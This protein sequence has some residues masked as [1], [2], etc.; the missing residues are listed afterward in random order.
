MP[1]NPNH[2]SKGYKLLTDTSATARNF[3]GFTVLSTVVVTAIVAPT[4]SYPDGYLSD[5]AS[6][7]GVSLPA[8]YYPIRG[9][10]F[11]A[12]TA[13]VVILWLD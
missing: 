10:S 1:Q 8:G 6:L 11:T 2:A 9:S 12:G 13:N 3:Y 7:A 5:A 4:D